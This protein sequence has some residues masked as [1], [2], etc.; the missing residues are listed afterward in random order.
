MW[1]RLPP[2]GPSGHRRPDATIAPRYQRRLEILIHAVSLSF[3]AILIVYGIRFAWFV[4]LQISPALSIPKWIVFAVIPLSG[5]I[6]AVHSLNLI[7]AAGGKHR[8]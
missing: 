6:L 8:P 5:A 3:F 2:P 4:R 1:R 7:A